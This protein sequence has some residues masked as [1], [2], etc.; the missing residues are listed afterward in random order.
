MSHKYGKY[1][2]NLRG[3]VPKVKQQPAVQVRINPY[4]NNQNNPRS[5]APNQNYYRGNQNKPQEQPEVQ[6]RSNSYANN[7]YRDNPYANNKYRGNMRYQGKQKVPQTPARS[8]QPPYEYNK[9]DNAYIP[10]KE[11]NT[12]IPPVSLI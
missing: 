9:P 8:D 12:Y 7:Q 4:A 6:L 1:Q 3:V 5:V 10:P 11:D 2:N